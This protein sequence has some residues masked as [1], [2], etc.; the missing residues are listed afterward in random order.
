M[1]LPAS[2]ATPTATKLLQTQRMTDK[3]EQ[4]VD[5]RFRQLKDKILPESPYIL[6]V[7]TTYRQNPEHANLWRTNTHFEP[8]EEELQYVTFKDRTNDSTPGLFCRGGW[9]DGRGGLAP[10]EEPYSRTSSDGTPLQ[11][12]GH[13]K[14][15]SLADYNRRDKNK[16][17][18]ATTKPASPKTAE[19]PKDNASVRETDT[20]VRA[21]RPAQVEHHGLKRY[22]LPMIAALTDT[23][24]CQIG[25]RGKCSE[26]F[27]CLRST[28]SW[29][30]GQK[31]ANCIRA[32]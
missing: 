1:S 20:M 12:Q 18:A 3:A 9:D 27:Y 21:S 5:A 8:N 11:G 25:K 10:P 13:K 31:D 22:A 29:P 32:A 4:L 6:H 16:T 15:I 26:R 30:I 17:V 7:R 24:L 23:H 14:K 28:P 19:Q 2:E